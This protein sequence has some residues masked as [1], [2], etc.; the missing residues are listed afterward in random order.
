MLLIMSVWLGRW[1][2]VALIGAPLYRYLDRAPELRGVSADRNLFAP[3]CE[4]LAA[5][6]LGRSTSPVRL[7]PSLWLL[8]AL[9]TAIGL[10]ASC[11]VWVAID[12]SMLLLRKRLCLRWSQVLPAFALTTLYT[13]VAAILLGWCWWQA[14]P[15]LGALLE[16]WFGERGT[17]YFQ[18]TLLC[19]VLCVI[20]GFFIVSDVVRAIVASG[21][22]SPRRAL[23]VAIKVCR[24]QPSRIPVQALLP[25]GLAMS[26]HLSCGWIIAHNG[27]LAASATHV[28]LTFLLTELAA[29]L[30]VALRLDW[31]AWISQQIM[32]HR[33]EFGIEPNRCARH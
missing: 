9:G 30:A 29:L 6:L 27:W 16:P 7:P 5:L 2:L 22:R 17:D 10:A 32:H 15:A 4:S 21:L 23:V 24:Q 12:E 31:I 33:Q 28:W 25:F 20:A 19:C 11:L 26:L 3:G 13:W 18:L 1:L 8:V 14:A